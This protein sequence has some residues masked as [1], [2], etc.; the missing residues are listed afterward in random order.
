ML[1]WRQTVVCAG[2]LRGEDCF[3]WTD[4]LVDAMKGDNQTR[5]L[6]VDLFR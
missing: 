2:R 6:T 1:G 3:V 5:W 4:G